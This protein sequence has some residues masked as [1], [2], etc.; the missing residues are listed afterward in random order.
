[1][2]NLDSTLGWN[3]LLAALKAIEASVESLEG[4]V[5]IISAII[6]PVLTSLN[7]TEILQDGLSTDALLVANYTSTVGP[8]AIASVVPALKINS[9]DALLSNAATPA[10]VVTGTITVTDTEANSRIFELGAIEVS[11]VAPIASGAIPDKSFTSGSGNQLVDISGDYSTGGTIVSFSIVAS[12]SGVTIAEDTGIITIAT[13]VIRSGS[14]VYRGN[15]PVGSADG[16]FSLIVAGASAT[17]P[18]AFILS[19]WTLSDS[20]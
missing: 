15:N 7:E 1:R 2:F 10:A 3:K 8:A 18:S 4:T 5:Q 6:T 11:Y 12:P 16:A 19:Q 20:P 9:V 13:D 14:V 17:V